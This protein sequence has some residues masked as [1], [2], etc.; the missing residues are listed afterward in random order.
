MYGDIVYIYCMW[1]KQGAKLV[2]SHASS[3]V[4][5]RQVVQRPLSLVTLG[6]P[7]LFPRQIF[8]I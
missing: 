3:S 5:L 1:S 7:K 4:M 6:D 2:Y 8:A